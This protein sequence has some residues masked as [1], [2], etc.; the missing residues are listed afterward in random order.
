MQVE[1]RIQTAAAYVATPSSS[2]MQT[3]ALRMTLTSPP[4]KSALWV[5]SFFLS[6]SFFFTS[7]SSMTSGE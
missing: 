3:G 4:E 6:L 7:H 1:R 5:F 2:D